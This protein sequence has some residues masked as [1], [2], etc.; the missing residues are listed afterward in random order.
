MFRSITTLVLFALVYIYSIKGV[1]VMS[2][3]FAAP[4]K[5]I[6][7]WGFIA[8]IIVK[9]CLVFYMMSRRNDFVLDFKSYGFFNFTVGFFI[10][11]FVAQL[12]FGAFHLLNDLAN[13]VK[14]IIHSFKQR[15]QAEPH[16]AMTRMQFFNQAGL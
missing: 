3:Y 10:I 14:F 9:W 12:L 2:G 7:F 1:Y 4:W 5:R 11:L 15:P 8:L 6:V 16:Q 13:L